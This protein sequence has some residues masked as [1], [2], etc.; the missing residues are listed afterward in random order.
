MRRQKVQML[1]R[2]IQLVAASKIW[3]KLPLDRKVALAS[4]FTKD[5]DKVEAVSKSIELPL[6]ETRF[7]SNW[8]AFV[9]AIVATRTE[10]VILTDVEVRDRHNDRCGA[11]YTVSDREVRGRIIHNEKFLGGVKHIG[12]GKI[13]L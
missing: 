3:K 11:Q 12:G 4:Q 13:Q 10:P 2:T 9:Q 6:F 7:G 5:P 1:L 8:Y